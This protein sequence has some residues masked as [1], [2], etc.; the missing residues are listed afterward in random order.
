M[1]SSIPV[2][3]GI[4]VRLLSSLG[5]RHCAESGLE[6]V[7]SFHLADFHHHGAPF[8]IAK[9]RAAVDALTTAQTLRL[10]STRGAETGRRLP[11]RAG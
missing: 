9:G 8:A 7:V 2:P 10:H 11:N 6:F 5:V 3:G 1:K 4:D